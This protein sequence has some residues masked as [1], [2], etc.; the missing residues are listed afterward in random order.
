M[1]SSSKAGISDCSKAH[2]AYADLLRGALD[3][4]VSRQL[5]L[6]DHCIPRPFFLSSTTDEDVCN[7]VYYPQQYVCSSPTRYKDLD[8]MCKP[9]KKAAIDPNSSHE[10]QGFAGTAVGT[11]IEW[12]W[13]GHI[14]SYWQNSLLLWNPSEE[15]I[16]KYDLEDVVTLAYHPH[17]HFLA[18]SNHHKT[19]PSVN[20]WSFNGGAMLNCFSHRPKSHYMVTTLC[21]HKHGIHLLTGNVEGVI[22]TLDFSGTKELFHSTPPIHSMIKDIKFSATAQYVASLDIVGKVCVWA[23]NSGYLKLHHTWDSDVATNVC[24]DWHPW[25]DFDIVLGVQRGCLLLVLNILSKQTE[26]YSK[27]RAF[28]FDRPVVSF[29]RLSA[30]LVV[31]CQKKGEAREDT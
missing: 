23:Y 7:F 9:R 25:T 19:R 13:T 26:A 22:S 11:Q 27:G 31:G 28:K 6:S 1:M 3:L 14:V 12:A 18:T 30:E 29:N 16:T 17:H 20:V 2:G 8:W 10:F 15:I 21:W 4:K 5:I 24:L